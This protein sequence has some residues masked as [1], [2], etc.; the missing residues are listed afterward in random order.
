[1]HRARAAQRTAGYQLVWLGRAFE[2]LPLT[3]VLADHSST[4]FIYGDCHASSENGCSPPLEIQVASICERNALLVDNRPRAS[5]RTRAVSVLDYG[6]PFELVTADA[7]VVVF[8]RVALGRRAIAALRPLNG[9][10]R[11]TL[12]P[13]RYP[14][15][16]LAQLR[17]VRDAYVRAGSS[18]RAVRDRLGISMSAVHFELALADALGTRRLRR[19]GRAPELKQVKRDLLAATLADEHAPAGLGTRGSARRGRAL[20]TRC[21]L[22]PA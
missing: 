13:P 1:M 4:T 17:R 20:R 22:E 21:A 2:G 10:R 3:D 19:A 16:Y 14:L 9:P 8:A 12:A 11:R 15:Y 7:D 5:L 6:D 18:A